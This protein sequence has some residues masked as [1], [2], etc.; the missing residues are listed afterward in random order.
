MFDAD[1]DAGPE[2][3]CE[4]RSHA[5]GERAAA[6]MELGHGK[7][8]FDKDLGGILN[9]NPQG[10]RRDEI[11]HGTQ[12]FN[13]SENRACSLAPDTSV[14]AAAPEDAAALLA[15]YA[16]YVRKTAI[17]YEYEVP[18]E[19]EFRARIERTL[20]AG[21]PYLVLEREGEPVGYAYV[22]RL[23]ERAAYDW[24]VETSIYLAED[25]RG[26]GT[27]R[28]LHDALEEALRAMGMLDMCACIA[29]PNGADDEYLTRNSEQFH[30][31]MGYR[32][33]GEFVQCAQKFGRWYNMV[34]MEKS[35]GERVPNAPAPKRFD[36]VR[37]EF[38]Y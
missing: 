38:G 18:S 22:G 32:K 3:L 20:A 16:P 9:E 8:R 37:G 7:G 35:L 10:E 31:H 15:I 4:S 29:V 26:C 33:V 2:S 23:H 34:W 5:K 12:G 13:R 14:R 36:D 21:F 1:A 30:A 28:V 11:M 25:E 24:S 19:A 27:G 17:T 6:R